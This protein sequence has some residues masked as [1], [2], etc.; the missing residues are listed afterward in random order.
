MDKQNGK[1]TTFKHW[2]YKTK[3]KII[4]HNFETKETKQNGQSGQ[5][6]WENED[7]QTVEI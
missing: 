3:A 5:T 1:I 7:I 2:K 4:K 6:Q